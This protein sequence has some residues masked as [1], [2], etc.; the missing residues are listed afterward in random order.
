MQDC[1]TSVQQFL[2]RS[3]DWA[4]VSRY[5]SALELYLARTLTVR[6]DLVYSGRVD[7]LLGNPKL[8]DLPPRVIQSCK[9]MV[10]R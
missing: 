1:L 5:F 8:Y 3:P 2:T 6:V 4:S 10:G 7:E 9:R